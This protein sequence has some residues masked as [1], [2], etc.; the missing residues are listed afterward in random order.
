MLLRLQ[1]RDH[2]TYSRG[3]TRTTAREICMEVPQK[4]GKIDLT[5]DPLYCSRTRTQRT[6]HLT[7]EIFAHPC[8]LLLHSQ[9]PGNGNIFDFHQLVNS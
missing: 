4:D 9:W 3:Q 8:S 2:S 7:I 1:E 6:L 5:H